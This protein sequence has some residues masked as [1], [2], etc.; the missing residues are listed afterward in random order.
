MEVLS[1][2]P[3]CPRP[4]TGS[5]KIRLGS[6]SQFCDE[7][8]LR[9]LYLAEKRLIRDFAKSPA[10]YTV[11]VLASTHRSTETTRPMDQP[12]RL[13]YRSVSDDTYE[14]GV[15]TSGRLY[16]D[17]S[18]LLSLYPHRETSSLTHELPEESDPFRFLHTTCSANLKGSVGL[19]L[20]KVLTRGFLYPF[21]LSFRPFYTT[22]WGRTL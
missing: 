19:I 4:R 18:R 9:I 15:D 17:F 11:P 10:T 12:E 14:P 1:T 2:N 16:D 6:M 21:D 13:M 8:Y 5:K 7:N 20:A 3:V 22:T